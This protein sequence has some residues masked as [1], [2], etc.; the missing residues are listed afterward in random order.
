MRDF[1]FKP[2]AGNVYVQ[3]STPVDA[4]TGG[5]IHLPASKQPPAAQAIVNAVGED[6]DGILV[7][8]NVLFDLSR[9][10]RIG[11]STYCVSIHDIYGVLP[12]DGGISGIK[13]IQ[14]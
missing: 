14:A 2:P 8:D 11:E 9:S 3:Y 10:T 6:A 7:A 13:L 4:K 12:A 5:G 1:N